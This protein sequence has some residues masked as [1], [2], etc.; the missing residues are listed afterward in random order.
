MKGVKI[1][2][3]I[4]DKQD[5]YVRTSSGAIYAIAVFNIFNLCMLEICQNTLFKSIIVMI[6]KY[7]NSLQVSHYTVTSL[8]YT[9]FAVN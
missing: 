3:I 1:N 2:I 7:K 9:S 8:D 5:H 4:S 6:K